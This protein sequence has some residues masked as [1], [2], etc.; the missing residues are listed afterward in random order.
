MPQDHKRMRNWKFR[1]M[2]LR[3]MSWDHKRTKLEVSVHG[4]MS[5]ERVPVQSRDIAII[6]YEE[7]T[8]TLEVAFRGGGVYHYQNVPAEIYKNLMSATSHGTYF[9]QNIKDSYSY[10]KIS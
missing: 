4:R 7:K 1:S 6:G 8:L 9:N 2:A 10:K 5:M 3:L